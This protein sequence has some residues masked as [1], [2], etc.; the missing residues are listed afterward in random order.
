ME[1]KRKIMTGRVVSN[2]MEKTVVVAIER[3]RKHPIYE[4]AVRR[5]VKYKAHDE[6]NECQSGDMVR[7][8]ETRPLS[9]D[10]RWRVVQVLSRAEQ[11]E[12]A[13]EEVS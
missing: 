8:I 11:A 13:P 5:M 1:S 3:L 9:R 4:K 10:K 7:I 12:I 2:K 6:K